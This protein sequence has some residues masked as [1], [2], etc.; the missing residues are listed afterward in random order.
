MK[1]II[2]I[3]E[4]PTE[5]EFCKDVLS[6]HLSTKDIFIQTPLI[7]KSGGGIVPWPS[8]RKQIENHLLQDTQAIVTTFIDYYGIPDK[9]QFPGWGESKKIQDKYERMEFLQQAMIHDINPSLQ[10]RFSPYLQLHEFEALLLSDIESLRSIIPASDFTNIIELTSTIKENPNPEL[11][12]DT[13][14]NAP[15][16]RL[17]RSIIGYNK[18]VY[19]AILAEKI[20]IDRI[21]KKCPG[22]NKWVTE[23][24]ND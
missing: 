15:S 21:R 3:C 23:M 7:K 1:R 13:P 8:L 22:F 2:I 20:G 14:G 19:G 4:G 11:I 16:Y 5:L 6:Q 9:F 17:K 18:I 12:N 24:E 10:H